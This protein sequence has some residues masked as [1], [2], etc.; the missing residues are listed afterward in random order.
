MPNKFKKGD[1]VIRNGVLNPDYTITCKGYIGRVMRVIDNNQIEVEKCIYSTPITSNCSWIVK[2]KYFE[3]YKTKKMATKKAEIGK[4]DNIILKNG[5]YFTAM[6]R[7]PGTKKAAIKI[8]GIVQDA[9]GYNEDRWNLCNKGIGDKADDAGDNE[10]FTHY[11]EFEVGDGENTLDIMKE[12][13][14]TE[15]YVCTDKRLKNIIDTDKVAKFHNYAVTEDENGYLS[16]G[17]G[18]VCVTR[19]E[20]ATFADVKELLTKHRLVNDTLLELIENYSEK[21]LKDILAFF[22]D[23]LKLKG[24]PISIYNN[25]YLNIQNESSSLANN[26]T[27]KEIR[28]LLKIV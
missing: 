23:V 19:E 1:I 28:E 10:D 2:S 14:I 5:Q 21:E 8:R 22:A 12:N 7:K 17:C 26:I 20:A 16:F 27:P 9:N 11:I 24:N 3:H 25:V 18:A 4:K 15:F 6:Y 13:G